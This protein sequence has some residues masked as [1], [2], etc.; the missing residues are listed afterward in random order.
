MTAIGAAV[1]TLAATGL[2]ALDATERLCALTAIARLTRPRL[3]L[4][5]LPHPGYLT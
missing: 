2:D 1:T 4:P 3:H 5:R